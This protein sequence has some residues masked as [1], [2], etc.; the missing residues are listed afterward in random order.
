MITYDTPAEEII[1][2]VLQADQREHDNKQ[3][4]VISLIMGVGFIL[5]ALIIW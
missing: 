1:E 3:I 5:S 2:M 4:L